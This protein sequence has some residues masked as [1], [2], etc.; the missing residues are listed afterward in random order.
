LIFNVSNQPANK[1]FNAV[2]AVLI[3]VLR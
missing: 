2:N 3:Y 1:N